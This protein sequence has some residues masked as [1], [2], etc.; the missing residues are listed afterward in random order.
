MSTTE[1]KKCTE[2]IETK[3]P[4]QLFMDLSRLAQSEDRSISDLVRKIL[5]GH[6]YG[7]IKRLPQNG[8]DAIHRN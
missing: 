1:N 2:R 6:L 8:N 4:E 7:H 3:V 5:D